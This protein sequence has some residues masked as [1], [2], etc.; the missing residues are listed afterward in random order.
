M[1]KIF[2]VLLLTFTITA[3]VANDGESIM[4]P[5]HFELN[6]VNTNR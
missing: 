4:R 2:G 6:P 1:K 3:C 5:V